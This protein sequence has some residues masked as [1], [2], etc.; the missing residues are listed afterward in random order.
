MARNSEAA[1]LEAEEAI[2]NLIAYFSSESLTLPEPL[3][4]MDDE[5]EELVKALVLKPMKAFSK[6]LQSMGIYT[7]RSNHGEN[8][9]LIDAD[10]EFWQN[11]YEETAQIYPTN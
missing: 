2:S 6:R 8:T 10:P 4:Y 7:H 1:R 5:T 3:M 11:N 9:Y